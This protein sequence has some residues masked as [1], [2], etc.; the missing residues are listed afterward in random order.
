MQGEM[1]SG[2]ISMKTSYEDLM[3]SPHALWT[4]LLFSG[5]LTATSKQQKMSYL[6]CQLRI[7][8]EEIV[9][10]YQEIFNS[11][12]ME[13]IGEKKYDSFLKN[14]LEG[15]VFDHFGGFFRP[16]C[17]KASIHYSTTMASQLTNKTSVLNTQF[18][19]Q[20]RVF[21]TI[22]FNIYHERNIS[23]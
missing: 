7:P 1:I 15:N 19:K 5:Y 23:E 11:W 20:K 16:L 12:L 3:E 2:S 14:L 22:L 9:C 13:A 21:F 10:Q 4:L 8:N 18:Y 17:E 6:V